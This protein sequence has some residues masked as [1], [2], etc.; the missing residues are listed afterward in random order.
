LH[1]KISR[2]DLVEKQGASVR[3]LKA[4]RPLA[5]RAGKSALFMPEEFAL[6]HSGSEAQLSRTQGAFRRLLR[7]CKIW[8]NISLPVP[9]SPV[10]STVAGESATRSI[11]PNK[12]RIAAS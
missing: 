5:N 11:W 4:T 3:Q 9:L 7:R 6:Q 1:A 12:R 8:A 10:M 2:S